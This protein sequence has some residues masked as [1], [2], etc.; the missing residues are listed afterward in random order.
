[1]KLNSSQIDIM[2]HTKHNAA[3]GLFGTSSPDEDMM[4]LVSLGLMKSRGSVSFAPDEWFCLTE[5]GEAA[6]RRFRP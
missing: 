5:K 3:N 6:L 4:E 2:Y 1:M